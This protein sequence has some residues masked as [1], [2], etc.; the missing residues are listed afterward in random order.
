MKEHKNSP[1]MNAACLA[2]VLFSVVMS[3]Y[4]IVGLWE[5]IQTKFVT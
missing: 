3:Y 4:A 1:A 5:Y 2:A